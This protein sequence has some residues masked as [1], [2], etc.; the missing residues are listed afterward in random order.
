MPFQWWKISQLV[1][2]WRCQQI[3]TVLLIKLVGIGKF[4][5]MQWQ[6]VFKV[7]NNAGMWSLDVIKARHPA[8]EDGLRIIKLERSWL[9]FLLWS[10][11]FKILGR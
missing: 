10:Y 9:D 5:T 1:F 8:Q 11:D 2:G 4:R 7:G 6:A 3:A